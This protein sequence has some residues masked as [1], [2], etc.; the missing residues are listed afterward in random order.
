MHTSVP[1]EFDVRIVDPYPAVQDLKPGIANDYKTLQRL[2]W[3]Q[4]RCVRV[5]RGESQCRHRVRV[6]TAA[7]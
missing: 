4:A 2:E 6:S 5:I 3:Q 7:L 1:A